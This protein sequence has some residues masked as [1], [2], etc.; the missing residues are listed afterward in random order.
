MI[1]N[2]PTF[3]AVLIA[4][5]P[6]SG[7]SV[8]AYWLSQ[9]L[10]QA[11]VAHYLLRAAPDGEGDWFLRNQRNPVVRIVRQENKGDFSERFVHETLNAIRSRMAPLLVD[12][13]GR[14]QGAQV[15]ILQ[16]CTHVVLLY[17]NADERAHWRRFFA[18]QD[19]ALI[20]ELRS[21]LSEPERLQALTPV[22]RGTIGGL[23]R[24]APAPGPVFGALLERLRGILHYDEASLAF[25]HLQNAPAA[26]L[27]EADL[28]RALGLWTGK[29][30][31]HW[32]AEKALPRLQGWQPPRGGLALYGRG[33]VWLAAALAVR[34]VPEPFWVFDPRF[35][36]LALPTVADRPRPALR[37]ER[38]PWQDGWR[39]RARL[40][41]HWLDPQD[42][43]LP[44]DLPAQAGLLLD[45]RLPRWALASLA[46]ALFPRHP[47]LAIRDLHDGG[48]VVIASRASHYAAGQRLS[49]DG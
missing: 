6:H 46:R 36:W 22:L 40:P 26:P 48:A 12:V 3:P 2:V 1:A 32:Q 31:L 28:A 49:V 5:P 25:L 38:Q 21:T 4:G 16:A 30:G 24:E 44:A 35:G 45:G 19:L 42:L 27:R 37:W 18:G 14:P 34:N 33:P 43:W 17:R 8:L 11:R 39:L 20:A 47:W 13:G 41:Q 23:R 7:K 29:G 15:A 9:H 10:R